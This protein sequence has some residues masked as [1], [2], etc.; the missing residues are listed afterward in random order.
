M[1]GGTG[2]A[3]N[4]V[5]HV[6]KNFSAHIEIVTSL[7]GRTQYPTITAGTIR[8]GGFGGIEGLSQFIRE[9]NITALIDA[10]HPFAAQISRHARIA[11][12]MTKIPRLIFTRPSWVHHPDDQW[13]MVKDIEAAYESIQ[14]I[15]QNRGPSASKL[16]VFLTIGSQEI[17]IFKNISCAEFLLRQIDPPKERLP[18]HIHVILGRGPFTLVDEMGLLRKHTIDVLITKASGGEATYAKITAARQLKLPVIM[19]ERPPLESGET[20]TEITAALS[21]IAA[22]VGLS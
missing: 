21:W 13:F 20:T 9:E 22:H 17:A 8:R 18:S 5:Q 10:T 6:H 19:I 12:E 2:E 11:A 7:A 1:L 16:R 15:I 14:T 4:L 3:V